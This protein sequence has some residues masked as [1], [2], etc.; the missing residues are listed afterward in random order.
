LAIGQANLQRGRV[1]ELRITQ[2][3]VEEIRIARVRRQ[4]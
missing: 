3:V 1:G 2:L 4:S